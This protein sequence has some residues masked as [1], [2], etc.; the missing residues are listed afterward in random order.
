MNRISAGGNLS[1]EMQPDQWRLLLNGADTVQ[2]LV[3]AERGEPL[4]YLPAFGSTRRLPD[5][6]LLPTQYIQRVVLGWSNEDES[7]HLGFLL[8]PEL[9]RPRG[10]RWCELVH[11]PDLDGEMFG[12]Q[13]REAAEMLAQTMDRPFYY[14]PPRIE[15]QPKRAA[16]PALPSQIDQ[17]QISLNTSGQIE[18]SLVESGGRSRLLQGLWYGLLSIVYFILSGLTLTSGIALPR[19]EILPWLGLV[20]GVILFALAVRTILFSPRPI[21]RVVVHPEAKVVRALSQG[22][23]VWRLEREDIEAVYVSQMVQRPRRNGDQPIPY[24][25]L[26]LQRADGKFQL[27]LNQ[28]ATELTGISDLVDDQTPTS[29]VSLLDPVQ[30]H[31]ALQTFGLHMAQMLDLP[32]FYDRR[33]G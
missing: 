11:W 27:V 20:V 22:R 31:S 28:G 25:E 7:W 9:A 23:E 32:C 33:P 24:G 16:I 17:W 1:I 21:D 8:E 14:V 5:T 19:P 2:A 18:A 4:R 13:A 15:A 3:E 6:G 29:G 12:T 30:A 26:N 10:S